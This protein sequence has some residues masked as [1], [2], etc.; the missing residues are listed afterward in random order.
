MGTQVVPPDNSDL[1][2]VVEARSALKDD[3]NSYSLEGYLIGKTFLA[4]M[5][6]LKGEISRANFLKAA[7]SQVYDLGGFTVDYT[8]DNQG[9]NFV[10]L[11]YLDQGIFQPI[12]HVDLHKVF[13]SS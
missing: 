7:R 10:Q 1:P 12:G 4:V 3:L 11:L 2:V 9:S 8:D 5:Y 6:N 13:A